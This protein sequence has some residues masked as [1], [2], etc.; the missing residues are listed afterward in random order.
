MM[1]ASFDPFGA[2]FDRAAHRV[3]GRA[4]LFASSALIT[5]QCLSS[6]S[7][8]PSNFVQANAM[9]DGS[10]CASASSEEILDR[11]AWDEESSAQAYGGQLVACDE[12]VRMG[13]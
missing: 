2:Y 3:P 7:T 8:M 12:L 1:A 6:T 4:R 9:A 10:S 11:L 13:P 5:D